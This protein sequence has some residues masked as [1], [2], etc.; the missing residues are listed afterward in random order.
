MG[1]QS[2]CEKS[3]ASWE[4]GVARVCVR[5]QLCS[6]GLVWKYLVSFQFLFSSNIQPDPVPASSAWQAATVSEA[7]GRAA[8]ALEPRVCTEAAL[9]GTWPRLH[10]PPFLPLP[11]LDDQTHSPV[12]RGHRRVLCPW[13][14]AGQPGWAAGRA[15]HGGLRWLAHSPSLRPPGRLPVVSLSPLRI[16]FYIVSPRASTVH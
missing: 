2:S 12:L 14:G 1:R 5:L 3:N 13:H 10:C 4:V 9:L 16:Y 15:S 8:A 6:A 7:A 11:C